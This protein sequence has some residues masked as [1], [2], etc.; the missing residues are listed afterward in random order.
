[1]VGVCA[2]ALVAGC[3][4][5]E[6]VAVGEGDLFTFVEADDAVTAASLLDSADASAVAGE[7]GD[8]AGI[9]AGCVHIQWCNEPGPVGTVCFW[10]NFNCS[11]EEAYR[12]CVRDGRA[13]CGRIVQPAEIRYQ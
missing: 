13:V 7:A 4:S 10:D 9:A 5:D 6:P 8:G 1:M 2:L 3:A 11:P 12:E